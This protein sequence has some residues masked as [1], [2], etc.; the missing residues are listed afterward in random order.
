MN[1]CQEQ[2]LTPLEVVFDGN[3][4]VFFVFE[5]LLLSILTTDASQRFLLISNVGDCNLETL[6]EPL[7]HAPMRPPL[8]GFN[9]IC[10]ISGRVESRHANIDVDHE[11][12]VGGA[13]GCEVAFPGFNAHA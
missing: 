9:G 7:R 4:T 1:E 10:Q 3:L 5:L 13:H 11:L 8:E 6:G 2:E 12:L